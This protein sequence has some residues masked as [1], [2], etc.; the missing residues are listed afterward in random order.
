M[1]YVGMCCSWGVCSIIWG[2]WVCPDH[3][4][5][6]SIIW[7]MWVCVVHGGYVCVHHG[8]VLIIRGYV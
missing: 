7:G 3:V 8:Y 4:W 5:V 6:C 2:M 1:G